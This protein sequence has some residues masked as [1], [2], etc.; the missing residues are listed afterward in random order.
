MENNVYGLGSLK[1]SSVG[2]LKQ[3]FLRM[4]LFAE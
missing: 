1:G 4:C 3:Y 2:A